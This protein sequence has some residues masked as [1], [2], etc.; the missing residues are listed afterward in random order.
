MTSIA[1]DGSTEVLAAPGSVAPA[2][3]PGELTSTPASSPLASPRYLGLK[4]RRR[5]VSITIRASVPIALLV[6]WWVIT[7]TGT[8]SADVLASPSSVYRAFRELMDTGQLTQFL[9][10]SLQ[11]LAEG[12]AIGGFIGVALGAASGL[13]RLAEELID[14]V[15]QMQRAIPFL[16]LIPL[17]IAWFG[18]GETFRVGLIAIACGAPMYAYTYTGVRNVDRKVVEAARS[19]GLRGPRLVAEVVLPSALP[20]ILMALR[21]GM[22]ISLTGLI[23]AEQVGTTK[24]I[25]YLVYLSQ[26]YYRL[27]YM[28]LCILL[29][30]LIGLVIDFGIRGI[31][32]LLMPWRRHVTVR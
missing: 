13:F 26:Q 12:I 20:S 9:G 19:F 28:L 7:A 25:G 10:A 15:M 18:V 3:P 22:G 29:Y 2:K 31:E 17:L 8:V 11:R 30:A 1:S 16:A 32:R 5:W 6:T 21:V 24:G 23:A 4:P 27:D 14:P